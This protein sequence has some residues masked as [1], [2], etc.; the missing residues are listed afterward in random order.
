MINFKKI[1]ESLAFEKEVWFRLILDEHS[2][3]VDDVILCHFI[4]G[5]QKWQRVQVKSTGE[6]VGNAITDYIDVSGVNIE[7]GVKTMPC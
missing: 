3:S 6:F 1:A 4:D 5:G 7:Y 2:L